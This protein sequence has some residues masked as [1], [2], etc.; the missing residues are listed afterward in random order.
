MSLVL[1]ALAVL[2]GAATA[3][4]P[5]AREAA[6][7]PFACPKGA[8]RVGALPPD[9]FEVWCEL[10]DRMPDRRRD[11]P[12]RTFYDGGSLAKES[13]F[14]EGKLDGPFVE[15]HRNGRPARAGSWKEGEREGVW[16]IWWESGALEEVCAYQ[17]GDR[18]G[19]FAS[20]WPGGKRKAEGR[21]CRGLQCG[22]WTSWDEGGREIGSAVF[23][24]IRGTP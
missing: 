4:P 18:H 15:W 3:E 13:R 1:M 17:K 10:P 14:A 5:L 2:S 16:T 11:G 9:G 19:R 21:Y 7:V 23:E 20:F 8:E 12:W 24:E 6:A 22:R